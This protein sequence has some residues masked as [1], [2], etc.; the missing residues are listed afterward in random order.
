MGNTETFH[1]DWILAVDIGGTKTAAALVSSHGEIR[2]RKQEATSQ[3]GPQAGITQVV[4]LVRGL[5]QENSLTSAQCRCLGVGIPAVLEPETD[6]VIW[7]P[8]LRGWRDVP[9]RSRLEAEL[10]LPV[11]IEYDGHAAVLGE[12]WVGSGRGLRSIVDVIIG[13]GIGGGMILDG[14]LHRG[15]NRLAGAAGWFA[16]TTDADLE[17]Q[18]ARAL[19]FWEPR[20]AGP[21]LMQRTQ[22]SLEQHRD[23]LLWSIAQAEP[24]TPTHLFSAAKQK[25]AYALEV[26]E[27]FAGWVGLGIANII[28]LINPEMVILGG[29]IGTQCDFLL[30]RIRQVVERWAQPISAGSAVIT[31]S[32]LGADAGLLGAAYS[33]IL[34]HPSIDPDRKEVRKERENHRHVP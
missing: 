24:L 29:G 25:D 30:P 17:D 23:S 13:T 6:Q 19:G 26:V 14:R 33:A 12:W 3:D 18:R 9:L 2:A 22:E 32:R 4:R 8:N 1:S 20:A 28:S 10:G 21:G 15:Q 27:E 34:R 16:L 11:F 31:V 7:A 5:L